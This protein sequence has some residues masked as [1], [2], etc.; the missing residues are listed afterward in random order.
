MVALRDRIGDGALEEQDT[1]RYILHMRAVYLQLLGGAFA[2]A[3]GGPVVIMQN[4]SEFLKLSLNLDRLIKAQTG[5]SEAMEAARTTYNTAYGSSP[6]RGISAVSEQFSDLVTDGRL[7]SAAKLYLT[8][9][10]VSIWQSWI[11][12]LSPLVSKGQGTKATILATLPGRGSGCLLLL[13]ALIGIT[14]V[15]AIIRLL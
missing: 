3:K 15:V 1:Q 2:K 14:V 11:S 7:S 12:Q 8:E 6:S 5:Y 13:L 9:H 4:P 10:F